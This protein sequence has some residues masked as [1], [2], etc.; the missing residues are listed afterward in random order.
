M[1]CFETHWMEVEADSTHCCIGLVLSRFL[2]AMLV[3]SVRWGPMA[4]LEAPVLF[5]TT[6]DSN[7]AFV[8]F[9]FDLGTASTSLLLWFGTV[10]CKVP[11]LATV[12]TGT[13]L[14]AFSEALHEGV[15]RCFPMID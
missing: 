7:L 5:C 1:A 4:S 13:V 12:D 11:C 3:C 9:P 8:V 14:I 10:L 15:C 6:D 2:V